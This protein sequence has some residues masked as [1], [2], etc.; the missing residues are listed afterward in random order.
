MDVVALTPQQIIQYLFSI[1]IENRTL[2]AEL[3]LQKK[4]LVDIQKFHTVL[5]TTSEVAKL[6]GVSSTTVRKYIS[7]EQIE[8]HPDSTIEKAIIRGSIALALDF[9]KLKKENAYAKL[10][11]SR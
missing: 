9:G 4:N 5:M 8:I 6:H 11:R 10:Y 7:S 2:K 1:D 3:S